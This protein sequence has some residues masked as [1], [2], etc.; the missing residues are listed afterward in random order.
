MRVLVSLPSRTD[1]QTRI[2]GGTGGSTVEIQVRP[3]QGAKLFGASV[4]QQRDDDEG[5]H[6]RR[7]GS[8]QKG[9]SLMHSEGR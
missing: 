6:C 5:M 9:F 8:F 4:S 1:R 2:D 3:G 7:F